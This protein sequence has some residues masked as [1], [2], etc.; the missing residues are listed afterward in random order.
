MPC[1]AVTVG[2]HEHRG[3]AQCDRLPRR[4]ASPCPRL[5][6]IRDWCL[7]ARCWPVRVCP[8]ACVGVR[9]W[10][11]THHAHCVSSGA[12]TRR[13]GSVRVQVNGWG[14]VGVV[15]AGGWVGGWHGMS[16]L[17][18][19]AACLSCTS[20]LTRRTRLET[21]AASAQSGTYTHR[22]TDTQPQTQTHTSAAR[23]RAT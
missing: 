14:G 7:G 13:G 15:R 5:L 12:A 8:C 20:T 3:P 17:M 21:R 6:S 4:L 1:L 11:C 23:Y 10:A 19:C 2:A 22:H 9:A 18:P 16:V